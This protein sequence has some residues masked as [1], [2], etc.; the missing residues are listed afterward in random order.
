MAG[1][2]M[3]P[4]IY[5]TLYADRIED[6]QERVKVAQETSDLLR[7]NVLE[8]SIRDAAWEPDHNP[9]RVQEAL[10]NDTFYVLDKFAHEFTAVDMNLDGDPNGEFI[11]NRKFATPVVPIKTPEYYKKVDELRMLDV[12]IKD[13]FKENVALYIAQRQDIMWLNQ[14][15][16]ACTFTGYHDSITIDGLDKLTLQKAN[17]YIDGG[18]P[19]HTDVQERALVSEI[20]IM[21]KWMLDYA[22][23]MDAND[24]N[25]GTWDTIKEGWKS[26]TLYGRRL[27]VTS[28]RHFPKNRIVS[29]TGKKWGG[30]NYV[31]PDGDTK[32][33]I[34]TDLE[35]VIFMA[36]KLTG[37]GIFNVY[38][39]SYIDVEFAGE[40]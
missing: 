14:I 16:A 25:I 28:M 4:R 5:N 26:T 38:A 33:Q 40:E 9:V 18:G 22:E 30:T 31:L 37:S 24:L 32:I 11:K 15:Y 17:L 1:E 7:E 29:L 27:I 2:S 35:D 34:D 36:K 20:M 39:C 10:D 19:L 8:S 23:A 6:P 12:S 21:H 3:D 13:E